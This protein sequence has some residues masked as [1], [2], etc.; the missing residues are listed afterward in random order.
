MNKDKNPRMIQERINNI[1]VYKNILLLT[2]GN[3]VEECKFLNVEKV[4]GNQKMGNVEFHVINLSSLHIYN[5]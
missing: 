1:K 4:C 3:H 5:F 2:F